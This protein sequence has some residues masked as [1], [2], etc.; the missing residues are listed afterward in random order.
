MPFL[1]DLRPSRSR[2]ASE[3]PLG[4]ISLL[5]GCDCWGVVAA[6]ALDTWKLDVHFHVGKGVP[7]HITRARLRMTGSMSASV[8]VFF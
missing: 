8:N 6:A 3:M 7:S 1:F 5:Y 4:F 2:H